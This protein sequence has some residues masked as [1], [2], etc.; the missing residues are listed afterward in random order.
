MMVSAGDGDLGHSA[1]TPQALVECGLFCKHLPECVCIPLLM[2]SSS[3]KEQEAPSGCCPEPWVPAPALH[4]SVHP[5]QPHD[6][7]ADISKWFLLDYKATE[8]FLLSHRLGPR[9]FFSIIQ[10][11]QALKGN[12][13]SVII[14]LDL[15]M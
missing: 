4:P 9:Q 12:V 10:T 11:G 8:T 2:G 1:V 14:F 13:N 15:E 7:P 6:K 5:L 3:P